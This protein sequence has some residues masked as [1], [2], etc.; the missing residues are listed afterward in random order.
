MAITASRSPNDLTWTNF[1]VVP[2]RILD[3][4]DNTLVDA[5]TTFNYTFPNQGPRTMPDGQ[6]AFPDPWNIS[7]APNARVWSG[8]A[9]TADLLS[10]ENWHYHLGFVI[11]RVVAKRLAAYRGS[12]NAQLLTEM[13]SVVQLHFHR[14]AGL[15]QKRYDIDTRHGTQAHYQRIWKDRMTACLANPNAEMLGGYWL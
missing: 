14:R 3:P 15:L 12:S 4:A 5:Y 11:A 2:S 8:V 9:Q 13:N 10:H 1:T 6:L 7:I